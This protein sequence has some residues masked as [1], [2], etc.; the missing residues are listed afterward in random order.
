MI[1]PEHKCR[2]S[3]QA[4][5]ARRRAKFEEKKTKVSFFDSPVGQFLERVASFLSKAAG[6]AGIAF[7][8]LQLRPAHEYSAVYEFCGP[9]KLVRQSVDDCLLD[10]LPENA[11]LADALALI[12]PL[13]FTEKAKERKT[14]TRVRTYVKA[15]GWP[16]EFKAASVMIEWDRESGRVEDIH[17]FRQI[18]F[19]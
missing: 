17:V 12:E 9:S 1:T 7:L 3:R 19:H 15:P 8:G 14:E 11:R 6:L 16:L 2:K 10:H 13:G 4:R 18:F 5:A